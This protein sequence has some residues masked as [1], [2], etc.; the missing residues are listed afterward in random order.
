MTIPHI[1]L[2]FNKTIKLYADTNRN[3]VSVAIGVVHW[4]T[5]AVLN[6]R[7]IDSVLAAWNRQATGMHWFLSKGRLESIKLLKQPKYK[8]SPF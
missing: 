4:C 1:R 8:P 3:G 7:D 5:S 2:D 6:I